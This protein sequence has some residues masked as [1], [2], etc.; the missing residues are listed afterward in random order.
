M[1]FHYVYCFISR[2]EGDV[3]IVYCVA[4]VTRA[5]NTLWASVRIQYGGL[6]FVLFP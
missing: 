2:K 4:C 6:K 5:C 3:V 1:A